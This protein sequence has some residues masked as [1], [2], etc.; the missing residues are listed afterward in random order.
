MP[1]H[2]ARDPGLNVTILVRCLYEGGS[3]ELETANYSPGTKSSPSLVL[4]NEAS[5]E[6]SHTQW[7]LQWH[8]NDTTESLWW[9]H[10]AYNTKMFTSRSFTE[11]C[12]LTLVQ[13][14]GFQPLLQFQIIWGSLG[15]K[16]HQ[17]LNHPRL[18]KSDSLGCR[19]WPGQ[20]PQTDTVDFAEASWMWH[21]QGVAFCEPWSYWTHCFS[22]RWDQCPLP[23]LD[24]LLQWHRDLSQRELTLRHPHP[25][26]TAEIQNSLKEKIIKC[27]WIPWSSGS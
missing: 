25:G 23:L 14:S 5:L 27:V 22:R 20:E 15:Q 12:L 11:Q 19:P 1:G 16:Y 13:S 18:I 4:V 21:G 26:R 10:M 2:H 8:P 6:H 7:W 3:L 24:V 17:C 9:N